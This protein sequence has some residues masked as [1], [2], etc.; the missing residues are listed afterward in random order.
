MERVE[1][2]KRVEVGVHGDAGWAALG[3]RCTARTHDQDGD[4]VT[5]GRRAGWATRW[6]HVHRRGVVRWATRYR[7]DEHRG[8]PARPTAT[9]RGA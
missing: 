2:G 6:R 1:T 7:C 3:H 9:E 8:Q 4:E 5:C